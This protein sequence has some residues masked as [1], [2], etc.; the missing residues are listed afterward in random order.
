MDNIGWTEELDPTFK[1]NWVDM[2]SS[3][4][5]FA[6]SAGFMRFFP[7][8]KWSY[9]GMDMY[10][11]RLTEWYTGAASMPKSVIILLDISGSMTGLRMEIAKTTVR[12]IMESLQQNDFFNLITFNNDTAFVDC[13][14]RYSNDTLIQATSQNIKRISDAL[15]NIESSEMANFSRVLT[16][17]FE[18]LIQANASM[19]T[20]APSNNAI[21]L[22][23]DG[24]PQ[25]YE[26]VF[27]KYNWKIVEDDKGNEKILK[28]ARVFTYLIGQEVT[29]S[30][31]A[32][33]EWMACANKGYFYHIGTMADVHDYVQDYVRLMARPLV[34]H[35]SQHYTWTGVHV[36][37]PLA[38]ESNPQNSRA[39][40]KDW[41]R[42]PTDAA[43]P[44]LTISVAVPVY[45]LR[46]NERN[47][48]TLLGVAGV[49]VDLDEV[50]SFIPKEKLGILGYAF[51]INNNG[52]VV[53][54]PDFTPWVGECKTV[55]NILA[56]N[57]P[58]F[59]PNMPRSN[60]KNIDL[61][62]LEQEEDLSQGKIEMLRRF[63]IQ[64]ASG[65]I[66]ARVKKY[67][68]KNTKKLYIQ[69]QTYYYAPIPNTPYSLAIAR[70]EPMDSRIVHADLTFDPQAFS[71]CPEVLPDWTY[72]ENEKELMQS[73]NPME[74]LKEAL[75]NSSCDQV[76][77]QSVLFD[78]EV[79]RGM[80]AAWLNDLALRSCEGLVGQQ[81]N[82][83][84]LHNRVTTGKK[85]LE[86]DLKVLG[87]RS[88]VTRYHTGASEFDEEG[89]CNM[90]QKSSVSN[91]N[92]DY[93]M[94]A[95]TAV[96]QKNIWI[97]DVQPSETNSEGETYTNATVT[98]SKGVYMQDGLTMYAAVGLSFK[99]ESLLEMML[100]ITTICRQ[101][102]DCQEINCSLADVDCF[103]LDENA[104]VIV[105]E[106]SSHLN[107]PF[108]DID[109]EVL[110]D[111]TDKG[112]FK[113]VAVTDYQALCTICKPP[114]ES[115]SATSLLDPF[116]YLSK[117]LWWYIT[118]TALFLLEFSIYDIWQSLCYATA[119]ILS[120]SS[121][122]SFPVAPNS[123]QKYVTTELHMVLHMPESFSSSSSS[124]QLENCRS[125][126]VHRN[127]TINAAGIETNNSYTEATF[128]D[129]TL[130]RTQVCEIRKV[131]ERSYLARRVTHTNL[132][133]LV[134]ESSC[135]CD[136][137]DD[138]SCIEEHEL[139]DGCS[140]DVMKRY[141]EPPTTQNYESSQN[142]QY[143]N[144]NQ[145]IKYEEDLKTCANSATIL[146]YTPSVTLLV[147]IVYWI[148]R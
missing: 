29:T 1:E 53:W 7:A 127:S 48:G 125:C 52:F 74:R 78:V 82:T 19:V 88:G 111:M 41:T 13:D 15:A 120:S 134:L 99:Y 108:S 104:Y 56:K 54:H 79:T 3:W 84:D 58:S 40:S 87:T 136:E 139:D 75:K 64:R 63:M 95:A 14:C 34:V 114:E 70:V 69:S 51:I 67:Y 17:A 4:Q 107:R 59:A 98:A 10:D 110:H 138:E 142:I 47:N 131:C 38:N 94:R 45:D 86:V 101:H 146:K 39:Q 36:N 147:A 25:T 66:K 68:N 5:Y 9:T 141:R 148:N 35:N 72:C 128:V 89:T 31:K 105:S 20:G 102:I 103:L 81:K 93:F 32:H 135:R 113:E 126:K 123:S 16:H 96:A 61:L 144:N 122:I 55:C 132:Y 28:W 44:M 119:E 129:E 85:M 8:A 43:K 2:P 24:A 143:G 121:N 133:L 62:Y 6:S 100:V 106:D 117:I 116:R 76:L 21:M 60:Y 137:Q 49:D 23:T 37:S 46:E 118:K 26:D 18:I 50:L 57:N 112:M 71:W 42:L 90:I 33:V 145:P 97:F 77:A 115:S 83:C 124:S 109:Y 12:K 130:N 92:A 65:N 91:L 11:A 27:G 140:Q 73:A 22:I 80:P 30:N